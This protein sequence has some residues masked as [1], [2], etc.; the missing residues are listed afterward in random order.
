MQ[1]SNIAK[2]QLNRNGADRPEV[3]DAY[4]RVRMIC[5]DTK[6][7]AADKE[8]VLWHFPAGRVRILSG[9]IKATS[10]GTISIGTSCYLDMDNVRQNPVPAKF[11][12]ATAAASLTTL[13]A[14]PASGIVMETVSGFDLMATAAANM[15]VGD[16]IN[17]I[18]YFVVD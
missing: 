16:T 10:S 17:G 6:L 2:K 4:G 3:S 1:Y 7:E 18:I 14:V 15:A 9:N 12:A 8:V 5:I 11:A 13:S